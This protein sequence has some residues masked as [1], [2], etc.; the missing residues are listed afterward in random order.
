M[1]K[2]D[3]NCPAEE[4]DSEDFLFMLYTS[5]STGQPKGIAHSQ[6]GYLLF[7]SLTQNVV[8]DCNDGDIFGCV[9]DIGWITGHSYIVYGPLCNGVTSVLFESTP[10]YPDPGNSSSFEAIIAS[11]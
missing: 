6:A 5:G 1:A 4:M 8:F 2:E 10:V 9:A 7:A 11:C 3:I